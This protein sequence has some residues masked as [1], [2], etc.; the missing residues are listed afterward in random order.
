M[1]SN[2]LP[3]TALIYCLVA[4]NAVCTKLLQGWIDDVVART[5]VIFSKLGNISTVLLNL[6]ED[7]L[8]HHITQYK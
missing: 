3:R 4:S 6:F 2:N 7:E 5:E 8:Q 1:R